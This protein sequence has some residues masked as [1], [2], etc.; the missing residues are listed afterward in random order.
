MMGALLQWWNSKANMISSQGPPAR[1]HH[2]VVITDPRHQ[3]YGWT[4][5]RFLRLFY[6]GS[7]WKW[8]LG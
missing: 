6:L 7:G 4:P 5:V 1:S 2:V 8:M 3:P